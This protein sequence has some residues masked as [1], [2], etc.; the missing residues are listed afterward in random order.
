MSQQ[1]EIAVNYSKFLYLLQ[2]DNKQLA[3]Q[4]GSHVGEICTKI[5]VLL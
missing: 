3:D 5:L 1:F 2:T 4:H